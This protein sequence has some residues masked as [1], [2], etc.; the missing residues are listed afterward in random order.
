M[1][2][3]RDFINSGV[4]ALAMPTILRAGKS[5][6]IQVLKTKGHILF[7]DN[8]TMYE[9]EKASVFSGVREFYKEKFGI[10]INFLFYNEFAEVP[11]L[12]ES[13][14]IYR[15]ITPKEDMSHDPEVM[16][17][18]DKL[19]ALKI[20]LRNLPIDL[21][22]AEKVA[23]LEQEIAFKKDFLVDEVIPHRRLVDSIITVAGHSEVGGNIGYLIEREADVKT[24]IRNTSHEIGHT[25]NL[26]HPDEETPP[27]GKYVRPGIPNMMS[28]KAINKK[29][30]FGF[31]ILQSQILKARTNLL[32]RLRN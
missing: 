16:G 1:I 28:S 17:Y 20:K 24:K 27:I 12:K 23:N 5:S 2:T 31:D 3:R 29:Q 7:E 22:G 6:K 15:I 30:K 11:E 8:G 9:K 18:L 32:E 10:D 14:F 26:E 13:E 19:S 21:D 25:Y 4:A